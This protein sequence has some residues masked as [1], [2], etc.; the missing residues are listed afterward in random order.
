MKVTNE[1]KQ[2][3]GFPGYGVNSL[4]QVFSCWRHCGRQKRVIGTDWV[5][6]TP[7]LGNHGYKVVSFSKNGTSH[8]RLVHRIVL[9]TFVGKCPPKHETRHLNGDR[10][11]ARLCNLKW[12]THSENA[13]DRVRHGTLKTSLTERAVEEIRKKYRSGKFKQQQLADT[14]MVGQ[15]QISRIVNNLRWQ[16]LTN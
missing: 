13:E 15:D 14:Y 2:I 3:D 11:D 4:G 1:I 7:T 8:K 16:T 5:E 6:M 12:G 9:E 10:T